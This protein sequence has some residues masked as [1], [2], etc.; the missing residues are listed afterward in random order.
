[1]KVDEIQKYNKI[2]VDTAK[3]IAQGYEKALKAWKCATFLL[4]F[5]LAGM[6]ALYFL[7]PAEITVEQSFDGQN[8]IGTKNNQV[9]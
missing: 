2:V 1:M 9:S 6:V 4:M 8:S 3:E 5:L 7:C